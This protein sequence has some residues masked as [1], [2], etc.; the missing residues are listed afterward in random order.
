MGAGEGFAGPEVVSELYRLSPLKYAW[1]PRASM[2]IS[3]LKLWRSFRSGGGIHDTIG[4]AMPPSRWQLATP[5]MEPSSGTRE[6]T[7]FPGHRAKDDW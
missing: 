2:H 6:E 4:A 7:P 1:R 3:S 5:F